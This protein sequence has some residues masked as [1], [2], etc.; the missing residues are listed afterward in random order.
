MVPS[1]PW[2]GGG[3]HPSTTDSRGPLP[4]A[5]FNDDGPAKRSKPLA[6]N[7]HP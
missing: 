1:S 4:T 2:A 3:T 5:A 7:Q 6:L